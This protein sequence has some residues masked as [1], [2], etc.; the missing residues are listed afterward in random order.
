MKG[1]DF[2]MIHCI[3]DS[4]VC[5]F[6]GLNSMDGPDTTP[7]FKHYRLG[8]RTA[9]NIAKH[10][11]SIEG[12]IAKVAQPGDHVMFCLGEIDCRAHLLKQS[13]LQQRPLDEIIDECVR[14]YFKLFTLSQALGC[15][16]IAW[17][18]PPTNRKTTIGGEYST[19]G[20]AQQRNDISRT[21]NRMLEQRCRES[22][23]LF[24]SIFDR[25]VES[26][27]LANPHYFMDDTHLA[28]RAM[29]FALQ[30]LMRA[31]I[32]PRPAE[33]AAEA[34]KDLPFLHPRLANAR[35][36]FESGAYAPACREFLI[37]AALGFDQVNI[38]LH[39]AQSARRAG[40]SLL[41]ERLL[42][43]IIDREPR[44]EAALGLL[45]ECRGERAIRRP[46]LSARDYADVALQY[47]LSG[48]LDD[49]SRQV[50]HAINDGGNAAAIYL[51][52]AGQLMA[53]VKYDLAL[54]QLDKCLEHDSRNADAHTVMGI[55]HHR[56][57]NPGKA[58]DSYLAALRID[59]L[60]YDALRNFL[61]L[62]VELGMGKSAVPVIRGLLVKH[63][64]NAVM[65]GIAQSFVNTL[66][67]A[68]KASVGTETQPHPA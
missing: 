3:G 47:A 67:T 58:M 39:A 35:T 18:V 14:H 12:I 1:K 10:W 57:G 44:L 28:Q 17:N 6:S 9:F 63:P 64:D 62:S 37:G 68:S 7:Y 59:E 22:R 46:A 51:Y 21:F 19:Y 24:I 11:G 45:A 34:D 61:A 56:R 60:H 50:E 5:F 41:A 30:E 15:K 33:R 43:E 8:P 42:D 16:L 20:T 48:R 53:F 40:D 36:L 55:L 65:L 38:L 52:L 31:G 13:E 25:I 2:L 54:E 26:D 4:H 32:I 29:P 23:V 49:A 66:G 27:G